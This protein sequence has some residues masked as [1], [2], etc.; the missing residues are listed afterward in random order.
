MRASSS[1]WKS[2]CRSSAVAVARSSAGRSCS[3]SHVR[4]LIPNRSAAGRRTTRFRCRIAWTWFFNRVRCRT[5]CPRR[6]TCRRSAAV[7]SS[8]IHTA[9]RKSA[10]SSSARIAASTLSVLIFASAIARVFAGLDTTTR[11]ARR[12]NGAAIAHVFP[13]TSNATTSV[14]AKVFANA[15]TCSVVVANR[16]SWVTTPS[17]QI[18][19]WAKSR[20]TS[21]P[22]HRLLIVTTISLPNSSR[23]VIGSGGGRNGSYGSVRA[24][25]PGRS[26]GRPP[27]NTGYQPTEQAWP[28]HPVFSRRPCPGRSYRN[29]ATPAPH[30]G[31]AASGTGG[32]ATFIPVTNPARPGWRSGSSSSSQRR[33]AGAPSTAPTWSPSSAPARPLSTASSSNDPKIKNQPPRRASGR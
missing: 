27:T 8:G 14:G 4:P 2:S 17:C 26:Q 23:C 11:A 16:P 24:A 10:A 21:C 1:A 33:L 13:V 6:C 9:G 20:C 12:A 19:T 5:M 7:C 22:M 15:R 28:A 25:Q 3:A 31:P 18:A 29:S 30:Q 32:A